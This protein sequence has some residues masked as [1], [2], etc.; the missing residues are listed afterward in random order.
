VGTARQYAGFAVSLRNLCVYPVICDIGLSAHI[1][2]AFLWNPAFNIRIFLTNRP[3]ERSSLSQPKTIN[4]RN[5][6]R[7]H[8]NFKIAVKLDILPRAEFQRIPK[9]TRSGF[10]KADYSDFIGI[11]KSD[12][13]ERIEL[14][15]KVARS[16]KA[17]KV[18]RAYNRIKNTLVSVYSSIKN[19][20]PHLSK[21]KENIVRTILR[22][23]SALG[24]G[25]ACRYFNISK[26]RFHS[27]L[28]QLNHDCP[29]SVIHKCRRKWPAQ[30][31]ENEQNKM[32]HAFTDPFFKG[33][34]VYQ[35]A[36]Y[37]LVHNMLNAS[38]NTWYKYINVLGIHLH[39]IRKKKQN[40]GI[41]SDHPNGVWHM[42]VTEY[43]APN[44]VKAYIYIL[45]D[46]FSRFVLNWKVSLLKSGKTCLEM[47][48]EG[49]FKYL[50]PYSSQSEITTLI[51][52]GGSE[53]NNSN[54]DGFLSQPLIPIKK[55][56]AQ[57]DIRFSNSMVEAFNKILKYR[58]LF[59]FEIRDFESLEKHLPNSIR[60]YNEVR[61]HYAHKFL[62]PSQVYFGQ[63]I[64]R[65]EI[66]QRIAEAGKN[67]IIENRKTSCDICSP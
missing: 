56:I 22:V 21:Y 54:V 15:R 10:I 52:D 53:N 4:S 66:R 49:Y 48:R 57:K 45:I 41:R 67:R 50:E 59:P 26:S 43:R 42:D 18:Y 51:A 5:R 44:N 3:L 12:L 11:D 24:L 2:S 39:H 20:G 35:I 30:L 14:A 17:L 63:S 40:V 46:N 32:K 9:S 64:N 47:V 23:K 33:W 34:A 7:Y 65:E 38:V 6:K 55:L 19:I 27:W 28:F 1:R 62:T 37:S 16:D 29:S 60:E 13:T 36:V 61:P 58:H 31:T 25:R 8:T